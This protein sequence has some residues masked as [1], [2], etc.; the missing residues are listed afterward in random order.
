MSTDRRTRPLLLTGFEGF[1]AHPVNSSWEGVRPFDGKTIRGVPVVARKL[2]VSFRQIRA[3]L[4]EILEETDPA[5]VAAFGLTAGAEVSVECAAVNLASS[6]V[7][8]ND[9]FSQRRAPL[10]P[11]GRFV[12]RSTLPVRE[13][14]SALEGEFRSMRTRIVPV[15]SGSAGTYLCNA[16]FYHLAEWAARRRPPVP[17]GFIHVAPLRAAGSN[18]PLRFA[19]SQLRRVV[20]V[21]AGVVAGRLRGSARS[22]ILAFR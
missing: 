20:A 15:L 17:A 16:A 9:G 10:V 5:A 22:A 14:L 1:G 3:A 4:R 8:D 12:R 6:A 21:V 7:S 11:G 19:P 18:S 2:P 13:I